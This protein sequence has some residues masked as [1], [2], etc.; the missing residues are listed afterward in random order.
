[1]RGDEAELERLRRA[2]T[3]AERRI[4]QLDR[5]A[6]SQDR[7][8]AV[9]AVVQGNL[10]RDIETARAELAETLAVLEA[11]RR[12]LDADLRQAHA[13][14]QA[15][16]PAAPRHPRFAVSTWYQPAE[17]VGGDWLDFAP[18][19]DGLRLFLCDATGHGVQASLQTMV[20][21]VVLDR[22]K[23]EPGGPDALLLALNRALVAQFGPSAVRLAALCIDLSE[24]ADGL[25]A[26]SAQGGAPGWWLAHAGESREIYAP[27]PFV[28]MLAEARFTV[29]RVPLAPG[30]RLL[31]ATDGLF[32][33]PG[34]RAPRPSEDELAR[35]LARDAE[36]LPGLQRLFERHRV[37]LSQADDI[38]ALVVEVR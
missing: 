27:G 19:S 22:L 30:D 24:G 14:Q 21:K 13:F 16:L 5:R 15:L 36:V 29:S 9:N 6:V 1:M 38:A 31:A 20:V 11:R 17:I 7:V 3:R 25:V 10:V 18:R 26:A 35:V 4:E 12:D 23:V 33:Q 34:P 2:L 8:Q 32:E 28:G 37:H